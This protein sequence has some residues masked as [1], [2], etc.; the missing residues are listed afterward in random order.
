M[1]AAEDDRRFLDLHRRLS[2]AE[3]VALKIGDAIKDLG[4]L[5]VVGE[6]DRADLLLEAQDL[7][8]QRGLEP[9]FGLGHQ[10]AEPLIKGSGRSGD[11]WRVLR[12]LDPWGYRRHLPYRCLSV[13]GGADSAVG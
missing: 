4:H 7:V 11:L 10:V 1:D 13:S 3:G 5:V 9:P 8:D 2:E 6:D 12:L